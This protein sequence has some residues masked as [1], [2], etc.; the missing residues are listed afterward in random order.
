M[1]GF[2]SRIAGSVF[3][4]GVG[5][6]AASGLAQVPIPIGP[7]NPPNLPPI[8]R[9]T[10]YSVLGSPPVRDSLTHDNIVS[11]IVAFPYHGP[12]SFGN[13]N[14]ETP[15]IRADYRRQLRTSPVVSAA[16]YT[17]IA[18]LTSLD[19]NVLP[20]SD[21]AWKGDRQRQVLA[22]EIAEFVFHSIERAEGGFPK[23]FWDVYAAGCVDGY[24]INVKKLK[25][26]V[27][28]RGRSLWGFAYTRQLD[29]RWIRLQ[30]DVYRKT[31]AIVNTVRGLEY[32]SPE[33]AIIYTHKPWY[34]SPFGSSDMR[35]VVSSANIIEDVYRVWYVAAKVYGLPLIHGQYGAASQ[36]QG[37]TQAVQAI[38]DGGFAVTDIAD[39]I[40]VLNLASATGSNLFKDFVQMRRE[41]VSLG[42]TGSAQTLFEGDGGSNA[43]TD[44]KEQRKGADRQIVTDEMAVANCV[45]HQLFPDVVRANW[46]PDAP[47]PRLTLGGM[48]WQEVKTAMEV[49]SD[50]KEK[51]KLTPK[52]DHVERVIGIP[53]EEEEG[54]VRDEKENTST[55]QAVLSLQQ[56]Y[57][58]GALAQAAAVANAMVT[59]GYD[60]AT[61][62]RLFPTIPGVNRTAEAAQQQQQ[63][64]PGQPPATAEP[65]PMAA[66]TF[67]ADHAGEGDWEADARRFIETF[68]RA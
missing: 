10:L 8:T 39:K 30:T 22:E 27:R 47:I 38:Y 37:I 41:D 46:G 6:I 42:I 64:Q 26:G 56:A 29:T 2:L 31:M 17:K 51:L 45:A 49:F 62:L 44:T 12:F 35:S 24:S 20:E 14:E 53:V 15:A 28:W 3:G 9:D 50:M 7:A 65:T 34:C 57:T 36:Q 32:Y 16:M 40:T 33:D 55:T 23:L 52:R 21:E 58:S 13:L 1:P 18:G 25:D 68:Q 63:G 11:D 60:E 54:E 48:D 67:S 19:P 43:H 4:R 61:A 66:S 59:L 5:A